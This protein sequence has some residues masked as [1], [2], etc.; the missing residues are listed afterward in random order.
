[1]SGRDISS[2]P[3][4]KR[5]TGFVIEQPVYFEKLSAREYLE[6]TGGMFGLTKENV[7]R[8]VDELLAFFGLDDHQSGL[9]ESYSKGMKK[10]SI[11]R[12]CHYPRTR[13]I[14]T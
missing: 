14:D 12:G 3:L 6:F 9:I 2:N 1:M 10:K 4:Y 5:E 7:Q 8:K 11:P 13:A